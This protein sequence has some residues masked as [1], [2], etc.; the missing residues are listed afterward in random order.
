MLKELIFDIVRARRAPEDRQDRI[1]TSELSGHPRLHLGCG[2]N[3]LPGWANVDLD[4]P[5][6]VIKWD[7][8]S[9][10]PLPPDSVSLIFNEHFIEHI[11]REHGRNLLRDCHRILKP[12]GVLRIS[13]P[14]LK[15][16]IDEYL[17][18]RTS[19]WSDVN[20]IPKT[21]CQMMNEGMR[22]WGHQ[23]LYDVPEF[24]RLLSE[25]GFAQITH[26]PWRESQHSELRNLEC[27]PFHQ[28]IIVEA[29]K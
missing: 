18:N 1:A 23:F 10:L 29:I 17:S 16:L 28:E 15:K 25:C 21:P 5:S 4:G 27:R 9:P 7:L 6:P 12:G 3:V 2:K 24:E 8:T 19:E 20:W 11:T 14:S 26:V 22:L 13:T